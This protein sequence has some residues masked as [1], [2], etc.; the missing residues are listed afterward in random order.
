MLENIPVPSERSL[1][2]LSFQHVLAAAVG[3]GGGA[4]G[5]QVIYTADI[6]FLSLRTCE[7]VNNRMCRTVLS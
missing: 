5:R 4:G 3:G 2:P 7:H 1:L 6:L